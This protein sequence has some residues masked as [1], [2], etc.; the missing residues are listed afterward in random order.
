MFQVTPDCLSQQS[1]AG[2]TQSPTF[3]RNP[4]AG[5]VLLV[6]YPHKV[7]V[8]IYEGAG[9]FAVCHVGQLAVVRSQ[10]RI[11]FFQHIPQLAPMSFDAMRVEALEP[12]A[13]PRNETDHGVAPCLI[14]VFGTPRTLNFDLPSAGLIVGRAQAL[15][16]R[17]I[18]VRGASADVAA[19]L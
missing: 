8:R 17:R 14:A 19:P 16:V 15:V 9:I 10:A 4:N 11:S 18:P 6:I 13:K 5:C 2:V 3:A 12:I 7:I 1:I